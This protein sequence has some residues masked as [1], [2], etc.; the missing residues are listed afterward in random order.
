MD[1]D[2]CPKTIFNQVDERR[3]MRGW[4]EGDDGTD[5]TQ[6]GNDGGRGGATV[7]HGGGNRSD[8]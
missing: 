4:V 6:G 1:V 2:G 3:G 5:P 7:T 8:I